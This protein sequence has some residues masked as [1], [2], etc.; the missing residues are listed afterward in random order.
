MAGH[1]EFPGGKLENG[2]SLRECLIREIREEL[3]V[4][5]VPGDYVGVSEFQ[6][7]K[8]TIALHGFIVRQWSGELTLTEHDALQWLTADALL[9]LSW[10]PADVPL[11]QAVIDNYA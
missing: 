10:S 9:S 5:V 2:E 6:T 1:W 7:A 3:G 11:V 4:V 8:N